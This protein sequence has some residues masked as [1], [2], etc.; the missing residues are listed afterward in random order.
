[1]HNE[2]NRETEIRAADVAARGTAGGIDS[3]EDQFVTFTI[4]NEIYGVEVLKVQEIIGMTGIT[5]VPNTLRYMKGVINLRGTVVPVVDMRIK[6]E[7][8]T[9]DYDQFTVIIIVEVADM[10]VGMIVD[11]VAD[12]MN[13]PLKNIQEKPH[14][15][16]NVES[17]YISG[18]G[19]VE[20]KMIILINVDRV[21]TPEELEKMREK[22]SA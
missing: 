18:I 19:H 20:E 6:F 12:V 8:E 3:E 17:D 10:L 7:M 14:Y 15:T 13:I 16:A 4:G 22:K 1:M 21:L 5:A 2:T 11:T 9:R